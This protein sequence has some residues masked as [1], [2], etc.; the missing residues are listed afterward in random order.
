MNPELSDDEAFD[1]ER[2]DDEDFLEDD[3]IALDSGD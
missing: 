3:E 1:I 2:D